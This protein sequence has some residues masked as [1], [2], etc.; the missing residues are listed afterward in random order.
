VALGLAEKLKIVS[1]SLSK[2]LL[3]TI[4]LSMAATPLLADVASYVADKIESKSG[5][6]RLQ[7]RVSRKTMRSGFSHYVGQDSDAKEVGDVFRTR[8]HDQLMANYMQIKESEQDFVVVCGYGRIGKLVCEILDTK[9]IRYIVFDV[10]PQ[11]AIEARSA[12]ATHYF[13]VCMCICGCT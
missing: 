7:L 3:T 8:L 6:V 1:P 2:L 5:N 10:N 13:C 12:S 11:K 4:A 9:F